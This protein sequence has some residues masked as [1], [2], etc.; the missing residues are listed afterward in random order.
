MALPIPPRRCMPPPNVSQGTVRAMFVDTTTGD[1][2]DKMSDDDW[3]I[4]SFE[5][6]TRLVCIDVFTEHGTN[7]VNLTLPVLS[8]SVLK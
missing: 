3:Q 4:V 6:Q 2:L 5:P 7:H 1:W 8:T